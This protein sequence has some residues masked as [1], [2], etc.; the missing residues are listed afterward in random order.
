VDVVSEKLSLRQFFTIAGLPGFVLL[1]RTI[2]MALISR[3]RSFEDVATVDTSATIQIALTVIAFMV[4]FYS[5]QKDPGI[6]KLIFHTPLLWFLLYTLW[7]AV[8][9]LWSVNALMSSYRAFETLAWFMLIGAVITRLYER[10][11]IFEIIRWILYFALFTILFNTLNRARQFGFSLFSF[12]T[13]RMEQ[14]WSTPFF[15]L[16]LLLPVGILAKTILLPISI[17][18]LSNTAYAGMAGGL[19]TLFT[20]KGLTRKIFILGII[21]LLAAISLVGTEKILK[22]TIFYGKK[23]VGI[24]YTSG[25]DKIT[26]QVL[27][28]AREQPIIGFGFVAGE[29]YIITKSKR[30]TIGAH[31]GFL[32]AQLGTGLIGTVLFTIFMI[33]MIF[34]AGSK[35]LPQEYRTAFLASA[36]LIT[37][38]T[39]G[40][41]GLGSRVYGTWIPAMI[42][43]TLICMVQQHYR[44]LSPDEDNLG[45]S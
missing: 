10:L 14:M 3:Q 29:T 36:I 23:G 22:D 17:F 11:E 45:D 42:V 37:I 32:S 44:Y 19:F 4:A 20:G 39:V 25:R 30:A 31:N 5:F 21:I 8:T 1:L 43:F 38:H 28:E 16:A 9:S 26:L 7:A 35:Y 41:P 40:N 6:R 13:L 2:V 27:K 12:D 24:E 34:K 33:S 15:F 18:S